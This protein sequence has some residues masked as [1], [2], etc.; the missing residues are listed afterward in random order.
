MVRLNDS[1][2]RNLDYLHHLD[3]LDEASRGPIG[4]FKTLVQI[5]WGLATVGAVIVLL[6]VA[7]DVFAQQVVKLESDFVQ[8]NDT[9]ATFR[10]AQSYD[11]STTNVR[12]QTGNPFNFDGELIERNAQKS[13]ADPVCQD[14]TVD[15]AMQG[16]VVRGMYQNP[17]LLSSTAPQT[18]PGRRN[19]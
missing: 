3:I 16:A 14:S 7:I 15:S 11:T 4:A 13:R 8:V 6:A 10:Y 12:T 2:K 1:S 17:G 5:S 19:T 18:A 9:S